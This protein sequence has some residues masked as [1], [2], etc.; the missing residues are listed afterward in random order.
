MPAINEIEARLPISTSAVRGAFTTARNNNKISFNDNY[1]GGKLVPGY[2][3]AL[4]SILQQRMPSQIRFLQETLSVEMY[5]SGCNQKRCFAHERQLPRK[6]PTEQKRSLG[7]SF[8]EF[9]DY[10]N[11]YTSNQEPQKDLTLKDREEDCE[12][13]CHIGI[14]PKTNTFVTPLVTRTKEV[15]VRLFSNKPSFILKCF[16]LALVRVGCDI[17]ASRK[18][19]GHAATSGCN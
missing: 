5:R 6:V 18:L 14:E 10:Q 17:P 12:M 16:K 3:F 4:S 2:G 8:E 19:C 9:K 11:R 7:S 1:K 13:P 15:L